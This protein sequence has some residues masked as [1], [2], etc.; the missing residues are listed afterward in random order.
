MPRNASLKPSV[1]ELWVKRSS[2]AIALDISDSTFWN[3]VV[4]FIPAEG[5]RGEGK[6]V[7]FYLPSVIAGAV[8]AGILGGSDDDLEGG[9]SVHLERLRKVKADDAEV[10]FA[11]KCGQLI[12]VEDWE[13]RMAAGLWDTL[14]RYGELFKQSFAN[15]GV[16]LFNQ[17]VDSIK[18]RLNSEDAT[19]DE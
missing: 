18:R 8:A 19:A 12:S 1:E 4:P 16:V 17:M 14:E 10:N 6:S 15:K 7:Q 5:K 13:A 11:V 9:T 2:A 3:R